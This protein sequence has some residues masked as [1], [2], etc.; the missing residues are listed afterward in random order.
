MSAYT[1]PSGHLQVLDRGGGRRWHALWRDA[2]GRHQ[3]ILG[4]AGVKDSGR[5]T[6]R[7]AIRRRRPPRGGCHRLARRQRI[8]AGPVVPDTGRGAA[9][10]LTDFARAPLVAYATLP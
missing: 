9:G 6:A 4:P 7:R 8:E 5:R 10:A 3:T 1:R 2:D